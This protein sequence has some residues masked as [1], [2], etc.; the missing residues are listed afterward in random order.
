MGTETMFALQTFSFCDKNRPTLVQ[1]LFVPYVIDVDHKIFGF[2]LI[3]PAAAPVYNSC[4]ILYIFTCQLKWY[5]KCYKANYFLLFQR[6]QVLRMSVRSEDV[7]K[8]KLERCVL[9]TS[10]KM[11]SGTGRWL[12]VFFLASSEVNNKTFYFKCLFMH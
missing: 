12:A 5:I 7:L 4:F 10:V 3:T 1:S 2:Q 6:R 8:T 11:L 9:D